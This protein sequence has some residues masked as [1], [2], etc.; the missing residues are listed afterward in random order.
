ML[1]LPVCHPRARDGEG[2]SGSP[3]GLNVSAASLTNIVSLFHTGKC[4]QCGNAV[5]QAAVVARDGRSLHWV[6][7]VRRLWWTVQ[8][9]EQHQTAAWW[10]CEDQHAR[11]AIKNETASDENRF[12]SSFTVALRSSTAAVNRGSKERERERERGREREREREREWE[13]GCTLRLTLAVLSCISRTPLLGGARRP[14]PPPMCRRTSSSSLIRTLALF[15]DSHSVPVDQCQWP[16][17]A[18]LFPRLRWLLLYIIII[19][20]IVWLTL[21]HQHL[22]LMFTL[23]CIVD[24][25]QTKIWPVSLCTRCAKVLLLL[26]G[27]PLLE[28]VEPK[29][30]TQRVVCTLWQC[31]P[32]NRWLLTDLAVYKWPGRCGRLLFLTK[33]P[34]SCSRV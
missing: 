22:H 8:W 6:Q 1:S 17:V 21:H 9:Q 32:Q 30:K 16:H 7:R 13:N 28:P 33:V 26:S 29:Q 24:V 34:P 2:L 5:R 4:Q 12:E 25:W 20:L 23:N 15:G 3:H 27:R 31:N 10:N 11:G 18:L 14:H 19:I